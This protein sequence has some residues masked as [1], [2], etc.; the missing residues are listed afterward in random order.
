MKIRL[1]LVSIFMTL[2]VVSCS[3]DRTFSEK[4]LKEITNAF[5]QQSFI[6]KGITDDSSFCGNYEPRNITLDSFLPLY[7]YGVY[8]NGKVFVL[9]FAINGFYARTRELSRFKVDGKDLSFPDLGEWGEPRNEYLLPQVYIDG[10]ISD[11][12]TAYKQEIIAPYSEELFT[13]HTSYSG[14]VGYSLYTKGDDLNEFSENYF[15][16]LPALKNKE[17]VSTSL[18]TEKYETIKDKFYQKYI[19]NKG[20]TDDSSFRE[21]M[22]TPYREDVKIITKNSIHLNERI[23][24][25]NDVPLYTVSVNDI[26]Y[27]I[28]PWFNDR[29]SNTYSLGDFIFAIDQQI[30]PIVEVNDEVYY[31]TDAY[32]EGL[33]GEDFVNALKAKHINVTSKENTQL[34]CKYTE[35]TFIYN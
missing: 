25:T 2:G 29:F 23:D 3:N 28:D 5:Y 7:N 9:T 20:L 8:E 10:H 11:I 30:E 32:E 34:E 6:D 35:R 1:L 16:N 17:G 19:I 33:I 21:T 18:L 31:L 13:K 22:Q 24:V 12:V 15:K 14:S 26:I 4:K 27:N